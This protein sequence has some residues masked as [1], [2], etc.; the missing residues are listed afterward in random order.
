MNKKG[1]VTVALS[2]GGTGGHLAIVRAVRAALNAKGIRPVFIGSQNGQDRAWFEN[3][4]GFS[5]KL[6]LETTGVVNRRGLRKVAALWRM[7]VAFWRARQVLRRSRC[8]ALLC[9]GGYSAAP[10][11]V[12]ALS[13]RIPLYIHEQNAVAGKLNRLLKPFSRDFFSSYDADSPLRDYPVAADL[14]FRSRPRS[15]VKTVIFLGGSQGAKAINDFALKAAPGLKERGVAIIHQCGTRD[16]ARVKAA[17]EGLEIETVCFGFSNELAMW[18]DK[19]DFAVSRAGASTLW[20]LVALQI[21]ALFV[22]LPHAAG[23]HQ[24]YN[25]K[26]LQDQNAGWVVREE[27][28]DTKLFF[29]LIEKDVVAQGAKLQGLIHPG[30]ADRIAEALIEGT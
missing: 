29:E 26:F 18:M 7:V 17:Y 12:A 3:D 16:E 6:F 5:R 8:R 14:F 1:D 2:G 11:A 13:L 9:V 25:A 27:V 23:D 24:F 28:L 30:G 4:A 19:A 21:P 15:R 22:P 20:E 10:A